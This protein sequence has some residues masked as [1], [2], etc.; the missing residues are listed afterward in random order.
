MALLANLWTI[1]SIISLFGPSCG[2]CPA[3]APP[4]YQ[5]HFFFVNQKHENRH[6]SLI[7]AVKLLEMV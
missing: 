5:F 4:I 6:L 1:W 2:C 7:E 3:N